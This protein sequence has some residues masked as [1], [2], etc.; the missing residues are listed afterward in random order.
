MN[1]VTIEFIFKEDSNTLPETFCG[2][3]LISFFNLQNRTRLCRCNCKLTRL[4]VLAVMVSRRTS[5]RS[6][7]ATVSCSRNM[8]NV[9]RACVTE[10]TRPCTVWDTTQDYHSTLW[11][12]HLH[13]QQL[14]MKYICSENSLKI[15]KVMLTELYVTEI[16]YFNSLKKLIKILL[17]NR[18]LIFPLLVQ[19]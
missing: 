1:D 12:L 4:M 8:P 9:A 10:Q 11:R 7:Y 16:N 19:G 6:R 5:N 3:K 14:I 2:M 15:S 17:N 13:M 18:K